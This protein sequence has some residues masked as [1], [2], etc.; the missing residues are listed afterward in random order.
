M[1]K[2]VFILLFLFSHVMSIGNG[3][4]TI[5]QRI[6]LRGRNI[7]SLQIDPAQ[8]WQSNTVPASSTV[9]T[10][11]AQVRDSLKT[12][13][14]DSLGAAMA[15]I[16]AKPFYSIGPGEISDW[17]NAAASVYTN[18]WGIQKAIYGDTTIFSVNTDS[19]MKAERAADS[20]EAMQRRKA[21]TGVSYTKGQVDEL[22]ANNPGPQGPQG[23]AGPVGPTGATGPQGIQGPVGATGAQGP[24]GDTGV[25]G[26][27]GPAGATGSTGA[28][29][30]QG[31]AGANGATWYSGTSAPSSGTGLNGDF[32][33][34]TGTSDVYE[35]ASGAWSIAANIRGATGSTGSTGATGAAGPNSVSTSTASTL[36]GKYVITSAGVLSGVATIPSTDITGLAPTF[37][38]STG[39]SISTNGTSNTYVISGTKNARV[40]YTVR[41]SVNLN[42]LVASQGLVNLDYTLDGSTWITVCEAYQEFVLGIIINTTQAQVISG[43]IP[44]GAT[45]R[46]HRTT[47]TNVTVT[48][49]SKQQEVIY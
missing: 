48:L 29:G 2:I 11:V 39:R 1:Q 12:A 6:T 43:D 23:I 16:A 46:I 15:V 33:F 4:T 9:S 17:N 13:I 26:P 49:S 36:G 24:K 31:I 22:I 34:R 14:H 35:K 10:R 18:G 25:V 45:V 20:L 37:N 38:S 7:D 30:P 44:A 40:T 5:T 42:G 28:T 3:Q 19:V 21:D 41:F 8:P 32:Y 27:Q 47:A